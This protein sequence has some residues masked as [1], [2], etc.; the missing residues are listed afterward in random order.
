MPPRLPQP[1]PLPVQRLCALRFD[2]KARAPVTSPVTFPA[3]GGGPPM[4]ARRHTPKAQ[5]RAGH[6][7]FNLQ[8]L[9]HRRIPQTPRKGRNY[10]AITARYARPDSR[11]A[12][13]AQMPHVRILIL[14]DSGSV[15]KDPDPAFALVPLAFETLLKDRRDPFEALQELPNQVLQIPFS[16]GNCKTMCPMASAAIQAIPATRNYFQS[17]FT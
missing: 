14:S 17:I 16:T 4:I 8:K 12:R 15:L 2:G 3:Q 10:R 11:F 1:S 6:R 9:I 13:S 7:I 5:P